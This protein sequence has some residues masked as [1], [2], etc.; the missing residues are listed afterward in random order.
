MNTNKKTPLSLEQVLFSYNILI[1]LFI[2]FIILMVVLMM[3]NMK[4]FNRS[5]GNEVFITGPFL[6]LVAYII[7]EI[8]AFKRNPAG[9]LFSNFSVSSQTWFI[10]VIILCTI[11]ISIF[12][13]FMML[14][15]GGIFSE[16]PP[17]NNTAVIINFT[18]IL[19][20][21]IISLTIYSKYK[22]SDDNTLK[23][24]PMPIQEAF[25]LRT[26]YTVSFI[27]FVLFTT[28]LY[29]FNPFGIMTDYGGPTIFF[30]LFVGIIMVIMIT[31]Y[32]YFLSNP[33][34]SDIFGTSPSVIDIL[35]KG[36]YILVALGI[37]FGLIYGA[38][39]M[40][41]MFNQDANS[42]E[43]WGH[44]IFNLI[45][46]CSMLGIIYKLA[47]AGGFLDKNPYYRLIL[48]T[49]LYIPCLLVLLTD[50]L[51]KIFGFSKGTGDTF[52]PPK[53][54]E[55]KMLILGFVLLSGYFLW[56]FFGKK[57]IQSAYLKQ[58]GK[59]LINQPISTD[60][61]TNIS[62]YQSLSGSDKFDYQ[63]AMSFWFYLDSFPPST[64]ASYNKLV[65]LLSYG[66]NPSVKYS[67]SNNTLYIT[68]KQQTENNS[69][70]D[71]TEID[72][73]KINEWK[74]T[75]D[76]VE[77]VKSMHFGDETDADGHRIIY[78]LPD[79]KLQKWNH[80]LLNNNGGTLD[81]FY[82]GKLVKSAIEV[83]P[84][85]KL[86]MLTVGTNNGVIGSIA[87]LLYFKH[88]LDY[89]TINTLYT[90]LKNKNPPTLDE[91]NE[92]LISTVL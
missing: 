4:G 56:V 34:K 52:S 23:T 71:N 33:S 42:P 26:K 29:L 9:S 14:Y 66:E 62:T 38:L 44:L 35:F 77:N 86:D 45:L 72:T 82:N 6:L 63:Y 64:N 11:L 5:F 3:T 60:V 69:I 67:S 78:K 87:N 2:I 12:G 85:M 31:I 37:S 47:N 1:T 57:Y 79:V 16:S 59:Q 73:T 92:K 51:S 24:L 40:M 41:G 48:N 58:G 7:K 43:T 91:N 8:I 10:P 55:I 68:V 30:S 15:V 83:V 54:F 84:Y 76:A 46:F 74:N 18:I 25:R 75:K 80:I 22:K 20:F 53:P 21:A 39:S 81:V 28:I 13:F 88:P 19:L 32:Q 50:T 70:N 17:E 89:L 65:S 90:S 49:I 27:A 61:L 36:I